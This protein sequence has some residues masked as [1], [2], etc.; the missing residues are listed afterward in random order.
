MIITDR[1]CTASLSGWSRPG[2]RGPFAPARP[3][4]QLWPPGLAGSTRRLS[5][6]LKTQRTKQ[7]CGFVVL[8]LFKL[9]QIFWGRHKNKLKSRDMKTL[10]G[11]RWVSV[12]WRCSERAALWPPAAVRPLSSSPAAP[13]PLYPP[14]GPPPP[15]IYLSPPRQTPSHKQTEITGITA[16]DFYHQVGAKLSPKEGKIKDLLRLVCVLFGL[17]CDP[18]DPL[19]QPVH[20]QVVLSQQ[21]DL[22]LQ[23][24][25]TTRGVTELQLR[26][27][28]LRLHLTR[29]HKHKRK[30]TQ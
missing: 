29:T 11:Y 3:A 30:N 19:R 10:W 12:A 14:P 24:D 13:T 20:L 9:I 23:L 5:P 28:R 17:F 21:P 1:C 7:V 4:L 16:A 25:Q 8:S 22:P 2:S 27:G 15:R 26:H 6:T 18:V